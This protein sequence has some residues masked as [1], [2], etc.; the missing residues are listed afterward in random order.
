MGITMLTISWGADN[1]VANASA[2]LTTWYSV[3]QIVG[4]GL[5]ALFL[6]EN[7]TGAFALAGVGLVAALALTAASIKGFHHAHQ[8]QPRECRSSSDMPK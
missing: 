2:R 5:V 8:P 4:P 6:A 1:G 7:M 3:G